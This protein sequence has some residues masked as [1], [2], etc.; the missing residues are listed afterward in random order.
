MG[1]RDKARREI[2]LHQVRWINMPNVL[3]A[4]DWNRNQSSLVAFTIPTAWKHGAGLS[5]VATHVDSPNLRVCA[6]CPLNNNNKI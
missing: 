6:I 3:P 1:A 4:N 5:I 2:F